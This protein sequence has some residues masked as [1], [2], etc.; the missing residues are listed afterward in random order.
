MLTYPD[1]SPVAVAIGPFEVHWYGLMYLV[2][3]VTGWWLGTIRTRRPGTEW[4]AAEISDLVFYFALGAVLGGRIGYTLMY[5]FSGFIDHPT[6]IFKIWQGGMSYHGGMIGVFVSMWLYGRHTGRSFF[7]VTD[8]LA[9]LVPLG[10]GAGRLGNFINGELWGSPTT[11]PW[12]MVFPF[13]DSQPRHPSMLY[14]FFFEGLV[15]FAILWIF[16]SK[17]RPTMAVSGL[18]LIC[19]GVFR[20]AVEFVRVPDAHIG[21]LAFDWVTM[22]QL[23]SFPMIVIGLAFFIYAYRRTDGKVSW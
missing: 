18:Y 13:V 10:L 11:L 21:F 6:V 20:F 17:P 15:C 3:F 12:G 7:Q 23:L 1:I 16:S 22:G 8:F 19:Y 14:E 2:A 9:P 5:N 4:R